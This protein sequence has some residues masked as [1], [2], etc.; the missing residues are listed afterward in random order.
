[1]NLLIHDLNEEEWNKIASNYKGWKVVSDNGKISPCVGCF[2]CWFRGA[3]EC[4]IKDGYEHMGELIHEADEVVIMSRYTYG[5]CSG[6]VKNVLDRSIGYILPY[7]RFYKGEMHH[8]LRYNETKPMTFIFRGNGITNE[9][10]KKASKYVEAVCTNLNGTIKDI[11]FVECESITNAGAPDMEN[12]IIQKA[13]SENTQTGTGAGKTILLNCSLRGDNAN[14]KKLLDVVAEKLGTDVE[15]INLGSYVKK[16][17]ELVQII[18]SAEAVVMGMPLYVDGIPSSPLR[19][20]EKLEKECT[21][22]GLKIYVVANMGFYESKQI[23]NLMSMVKTWCDKSGLKYCGGVAVGAG[24]M[25]G[26]VLKFGS[27]GPARNVYE[28]LEKLAAAIKASDSIGDI[29]AD[30]N[31]FPRILYFIAANSGMKKS[32]KAGGVSH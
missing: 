25:M 19:L 16:P 17:D 13:S 23:K 29:Y 3:G 8:R 15:W 10:K 12:I 4:V 7:F 22:S 24:E 31:K 26:Q 32:V 27:N 21:G 18:K 2:G 5:G 30:A 6:F 14:S 1:M 20:M 9:E 28:G 11:R